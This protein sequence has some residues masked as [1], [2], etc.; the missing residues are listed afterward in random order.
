MKSTF[1]FA[2]LASSVLAQFDQNSAPFRLF[3]KSDNETLDG[4]SLGACHEGAAIEGFCPSG[5]TRA[6]ESTTYDT[7][8]LQT[9]AFTESP[10]DDP[11]GVLA[12]NLTVNGGEIVPS[13]MLLSTDVTTDVAVPI[14]SPGNSTISTVSFTSGGCMY[15]SRY[16]DDTV[17]PPVPLDPVEKVENC[18][19]SD[20]NCV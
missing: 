10:G 7:F 18:S 9:S 6:N 20:K 2:A 4:Q 11:Y 19:E 16:L 1:I 5:L 15:I 8:Y 12:W 14:L 13:G 17:S 3:I